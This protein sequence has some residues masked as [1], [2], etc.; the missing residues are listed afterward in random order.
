MIFFLNRISFLKQLRI[1]LRTQNYILKTILEDV[2]QVDRKWVR[3]LSHGYFQRLFSE[4]HFRKYYQRNRT[5]LLFWFQIYVNTRY[6]W[7]ERESLV[8][9]SPYGNQV[10][11]HKIQAST[12]KMNYSEEI[13]L[14][15]Q[16]SHYSQMEGYLQ[17]NTFP[18][19]LMITESSIPAIL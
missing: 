13:S 12:E 7:N 14:L 15:C 5:H 1:C 18:T 8:L 19:H 6:E 3:V 16:H 11:M 9:I 17:E 4:N 2:F 10:N